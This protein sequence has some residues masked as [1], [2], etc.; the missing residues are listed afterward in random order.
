MRFIAV[1]GVL[2]VLASCSDS[3]IKDLKF[4]CFAKNLESPNF[5][6]SLDANLS[7]IKL[8]NYRSYYFYPYYESPDDIYFMSYPPE[9]LN[10]DFEDIEIVFNKSQSSMTVR[11]SSIARP[12]IEFS[13]CEQIK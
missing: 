9:Y 3:D 7:M 2:L 10:S 5:T 13:G 8:T 4:S 6:L 1:V 12:D 11:E